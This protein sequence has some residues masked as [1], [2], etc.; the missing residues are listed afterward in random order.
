M[1][2]ALISHQ[3][4][5]GDGQGRVNYEIARATLD[6][7]HDVTLIAERCAEDLSSHERGTFISIATSK[8][9]TR[10]LKNLSFAV[11]SARWLRKN[12]RSI[13]LVQANG[14]ITLA[15]VDIV[16]AHF[17]HGA[18]LRSPY[19][20]PSETRWTASG[21][22]QRIYSRLNAIL[23]QTALRRAR[24]VVAVSKNVADELIS[25]GVVADRIVIIFNGVDTD[26]FCPRATDRSVNGAPAGALTFLFAGDL[27]TSRK[28]FDGVLKA[29][30]AVEGV[31]LAAAGGITNSPF[32]A[33]A[34]RLGVAD[35][36]HF[37]GQ[38]K[39]MS[40]LMVATDG[41]LFPSRYDPFGLVVLE[42]MASGL[43]VITSAATGASAVLQDPQW[44]IEDP[45]DHEEL[46]NKLRRLAESPS[47]RAGIGLENRQKSLSHS[48]HS[49]AEAYIRLY[50]DLNLQDSVR[51]GLAEGS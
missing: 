6:A 11:R 22:Y 28:N 31:H 17:V 21:I 25:V 39:N 13:D 24:K 1:R 40:D 5:F 30:G 9:P 44:C 47:L 48:W 20:S 51:Q 32:P 23:E 2:V 46:V 49:M 19:A 50:R 27:R 37:L 42:A 16:A 41:F 7:G 14:F 4:G 3:V 33:L 34:K 26:E 36:V 8:L 45:E 15:R 18:W 38:V 12:R 43:P 29:I 10:F 35:R